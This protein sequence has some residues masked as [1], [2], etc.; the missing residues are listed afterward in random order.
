MLLCVNTIATE[1]EVVPFQLYWCKITFLT[2][3]LNLSLILWPGW[4]LDLVYI[5]WFVSSVEILLSCGGVHE[6][7]TRSEV[8]RSCGQ[9]KDVFLSALTTCSIG[10]ISLTQIKGIGNVGL[11]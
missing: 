10:N 1:L 2:E 3:E 6:S 4:A 5:G 11:Y 9:Q 8:L 7:R